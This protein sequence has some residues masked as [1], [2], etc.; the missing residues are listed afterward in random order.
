MAPK[1]KAPAG[2]VR[3][4][5]TRKLVKAAQRAAK[6]GREG[7]EGREAGRQEGH[8]GQAEA[9]PR[10]AGQEE[11]EGPIGRPCRRG[12]TWIAAIPSTLASRRSV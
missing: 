10:E 7:R 5:A 2:K 12:A 8:E 4:K 11:Q 9:R 3:P 6:E 1:K